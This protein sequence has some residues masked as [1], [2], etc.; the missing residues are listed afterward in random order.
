MELSFREINLQWKLFTM[1][2]ERSMTFVATFALRFSIKKLVQK[3]SA[4]CFAE[5]MAVGG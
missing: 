5:S 1:N 3:I 4:K 2:T